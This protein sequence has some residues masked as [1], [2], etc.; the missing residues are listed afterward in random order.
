MEYAIGNIN[1]DAKSIFSSSE[2]DKSKFI[3]DPL[4]K[5]E[6]TLFMLGFSTK[7]SCIGQTFVVPGFNFS[8]GI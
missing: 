1:N 2:E 3:F 7:I 6:F 4:I 5:F 8:V